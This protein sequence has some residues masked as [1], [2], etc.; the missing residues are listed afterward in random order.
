MEN[1]NVISKVITIEDSNGDS[2]MSFEIDIL[3]N[4]IRMEN[5]NVADID[6][7]Y[8]FDTNKELIRLQA[9]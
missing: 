8:I 5:C 1:V 3:G 4:I 2:I 7:D 9:E 6:Y